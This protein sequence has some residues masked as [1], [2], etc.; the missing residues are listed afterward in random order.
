[1]NLK[2]VNCQTKKT[3][4]WFSYENGILCRMC[5]SGYPD[6][7]ELTPNEY[8]KQNGWKNLIEVRKLIDT[9]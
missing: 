6:V 9:T 7:K 3:P 5:A 8:L 1:L 2:C 4:K